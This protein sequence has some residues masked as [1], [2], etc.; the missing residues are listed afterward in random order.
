MIPRRQNLSTPAH[1]APNV[2]KEEDTENDFERR[3]CGVQI[4]D[5]HDLLRRAATRSTLVFLFI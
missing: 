5:H 1:K 4:S 3:F 2:N